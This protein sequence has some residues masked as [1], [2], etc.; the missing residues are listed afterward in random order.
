MNIFTKIAATALT[1]ASLLAS[2]AAPASAASNHQDHVQLAHTIATTGVDLFV[3]PDYCHEQSD[4]NK[5][6]GFYA[7]AQRVMVICP[8][9]AGI[10][11]KGVAWTEEDYDT[12]RHEAQ[13][14]IQDC[15]D[16]E[17]DAELVPYLDDPIYHARTV[18]G[19][20]ALVSIARSYSE[21]GA[22]E[23]TIILEFEAFA[24]AEQ[25]LPLAQVRVIQEVCPVFN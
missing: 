20:D 24:V 22:D 10:G 8:E 13:H 11:E 2:L 5:F 21:S 9:N 14:L 19:Y 3:N 7:G 15:I 6:Y 16:G 4:G 18:L 23:E 25:N 12:L 17:L 1:S